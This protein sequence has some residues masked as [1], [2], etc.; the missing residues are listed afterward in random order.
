MKH[1]SAYWDKKPEM[2]DDFLTNIAD[3]DVVTLDSGM[4]W[5]D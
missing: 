1:S 2:I 4:K 3:L 5:V